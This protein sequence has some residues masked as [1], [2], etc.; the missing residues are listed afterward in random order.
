MK[1]LLLALALIPSIQAMGPETIASQKEGLSELFSYFATQRL[2]EQTQLPQENYVRVRNVTGKD[3]RVVI[4]TDN[5][6]IA[7]LVKA[8]AAQLNTTREFRLL[9]RVGSENITLYDKPATTPLKELGV[10]VTSKPIIFIM[11]RGALGQTAS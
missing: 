5:P 7:D 1:K 10:D 6:T 2:P 4:N 9:T 3:F 11:F 8:I